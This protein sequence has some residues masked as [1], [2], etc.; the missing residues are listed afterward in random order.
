MS[1]AKSGAAILP[2]I[3]CGVAQA[4]PP[5]ENDQGFR[6]ALLSISV[7][8]PPRLRRLRD[9]RPLASFGACL[10]GRRVSIRA[11]GGAALAMVRLR[12]GDTVSLV[13]RFRGRVFYGRPVEPPC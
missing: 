1:P 6:R 2:P 10:G 13:G 8:T 4:A 5:L 7:L 12:K 11:R 9:G 3:L